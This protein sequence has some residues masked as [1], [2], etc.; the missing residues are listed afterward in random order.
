MISM[1]QYFLGH[2]GKGEMESRAKN[3]KLAFWGF[4]VGA[5]PNP[6]QLLMK[7]VLRE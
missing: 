2:K 7:T 6:G 3:F 4:R 1:K 5:Y